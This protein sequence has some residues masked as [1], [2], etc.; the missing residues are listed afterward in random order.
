MVDIT[1]EVLAILFKGRF[2]VLEKKLTSEL[3]LAEEI[4]DIDADED[5]YLG[6]I[7]QFLAQFEVAAGTK[8]ANHGMKD[9]EV[10]HSR[11][12]AVELVHQPRTGIIEELGTHYGLAF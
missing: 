12:D 4:V 6:D 9:V 3:R 7:F 2:F 1:K 11:G 10:G 8:I 5:A